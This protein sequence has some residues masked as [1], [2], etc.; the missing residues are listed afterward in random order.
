MYKDTNVERGVTTFFYKSHQ[1][2]EVQREYSLNYYNSRKKKFRFFW[3]FGATISS[4]QFR[5]LQVGEV[6]NT[7][8]CEQKLQIL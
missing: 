8:F 7:N 4:V 2:R 5:V 3:C 6:A 1:K